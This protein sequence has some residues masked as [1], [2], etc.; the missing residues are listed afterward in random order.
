MVGRRQPH[1]MFLVLSLSPAQPEGG[2][3]KKSY[4]LLLPKNNRFQVDTN[5]GQHLYEN[6]TAQHL[7]K[8]FHL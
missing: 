1:V 2:E 8:I 3:Q 7:L 4:Y 5:Q 6:L